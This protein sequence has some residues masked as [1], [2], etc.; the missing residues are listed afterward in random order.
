MRALGLK[1]KSGLEEDRSFSTRTCGLV[2]LPE[3]VEM[4][5]SPPRSRSHYA[6]RWNLGNVK[7]QFGSD[8]MR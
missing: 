4:R 6:R 8:R 3:R 5:P 2:C 1:G 7:S